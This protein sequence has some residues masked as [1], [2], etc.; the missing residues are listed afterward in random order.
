MPIF[1]R[2]KIKKEIG[3]SK[4]GLSKPSNFPIF[5]NFWSLPNPTRPG[6]VSTYLKT[7]ILIRNPIENQYFD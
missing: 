1:E 2:T 3:I 4:V 5:S 6:R 7:S